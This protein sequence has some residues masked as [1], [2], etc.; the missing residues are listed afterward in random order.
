MLYVL[1]FALATF[2][3]LALAFAFGTIGAIG[4]GFAACGLALVSFAAML[5]SAYVYQ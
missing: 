3:H 2:F 4:L 5:Y 1:L